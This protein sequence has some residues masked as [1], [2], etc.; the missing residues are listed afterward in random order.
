MC[1]VDVSGDREFCSHIAH[2]DERA[3]RDTHA[4][5]ASYDQYLQSTILAYGGSKSTTRHLSSGISSRLTRPIKNPRPFG[6]G[7]DPS[8]PKRSTGSSLWMLLIHCLWKV[9]LQ[10][11]L[12]EK[13]LIYFA[14]LSAIKRL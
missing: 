3:A 13:F 4:I 1:I 10:A 7:L 8:A 14:L 11:V 9:Y 5:G 2:D 12:E 6:F